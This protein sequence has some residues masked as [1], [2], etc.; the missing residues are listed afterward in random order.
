MYAV[1]VVAVDRRSVVSAP[2]LRGRPAIRDNLKALRDVGLDRFRSEALAIR[3][4]RIVLQRVAFS[5]ADGR[6]MKTLSVN[7]WANGEVVY[8]AVFDEDAL[9]EAVAEL[10]ARY[11]AGEGVPRC[12]TPRID[13]RRY[14]RAAGLRGSV[15]GPRLVVVPERGSRTTSSTTTGVPASAPAGVSGGRRPSPSSRR[16]RPSDSWR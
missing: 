11:L 8:R 12:V 7:E 4:D 15:P 6:E 9:D 3:G 2:T 16:S 10:D 14:P 13:Q 5:T 1:D